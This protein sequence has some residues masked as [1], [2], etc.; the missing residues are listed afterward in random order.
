ME[1]WG[2]EYAKYASALADNISLAVSICPKDAL[3]LTTRAALAGC[4]TT[5]T[6]VARKDTAAM[7]T[8]AIWTDCFLGGG[9]NVVMVCGI[10]IRTRVEE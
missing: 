8:E 9:K 6:W 2:A 10:K 1:S 5:D 4:L 3:A 7:V